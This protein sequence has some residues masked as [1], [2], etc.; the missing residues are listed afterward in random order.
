MGVRVGLAVG[1]GATDGAG[2][3]V[4]DGAG[5]GITDGAGVSTIV[6]RVV[7]FQGS[8]IAII[9]IKPNTIA[10]LMTPMII[11]KA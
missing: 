1:T 10:K 2:T 8:M 11:S 9:T 3:G 6:D 5:T 7:A 4:T